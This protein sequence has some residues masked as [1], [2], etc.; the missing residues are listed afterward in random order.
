M[1]G[2]VL[3][4]AEDVGKK[5]CKDLKR[6]LWY[7]AQDLVK[8]IVGGER[9]TDLRKDEF[10][11]VQDINFE[12]RRGQC[13]GL[14]GHNGAGKSTLLKMLNGLIRPDKGS[15][16][17]RG[18]V[19][20][21]IELGAGFNPILTGRENIYNNAA[22]LGFTKKETDKKLDEIIAFAEIE[23]FLD[24]PVQNYSSGMRVRLGFAVAAQMDPDILLIDEVLA[25]GDIG[26]VLKCF[27]RM[28]ELLGN[29]AMIFVSHSMPQVARMSTNILLMD[30]GKEVI[31]TDDVAAGVTA[32]YSQ[33]QME[34]GKEQLSPIASMTAVRITSEGK[35]YTKGDNIIINYN[36]PMEIEVEV[37][38]KEEVENPRVFLIFAD[39]EQRN[40]GEVLNFRE[41]INVPKCKGKFVAKALLPNANFAQG[42]YSITVG[43]GQE[44]N[45]VRETIFRNQSAIY[46]TIHG[47]KHGWA[48]IQYNLD[49]QL[50]NA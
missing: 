46:F 28:D 32:Y 3:I 6:S 40:F 37:D 8:T 39:R 43:F 5:F 33:F 11:A 29:T 22:I 42:K 47:T 30:H 23:K 50:L 12:V 19:G 27:K 7:G 26:F 34:V 10:W 38:C 20:A 21:L 13:L 17:M 15:I 36:A 2:E 9:S 44:R 16:T 18:R 49:W 45:G 4:T 25:V 31:Y 48:P 24:M 14:I 35:T 1:A 41:V